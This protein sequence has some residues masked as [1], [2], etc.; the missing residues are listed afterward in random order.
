[1]FFYI[2]GIYIKFLLTVYYEV[3]NLRYC[4]KIYF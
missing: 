3:K 1:M 4:D 2:V